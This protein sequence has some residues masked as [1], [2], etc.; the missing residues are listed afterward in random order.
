MW[1]QH[2]DDDYEYHD[3]R[4][5]LEIQGFNVDGLSDEEFSELYDDEFPF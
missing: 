5:E 1:V 2:I 4:E 3:I